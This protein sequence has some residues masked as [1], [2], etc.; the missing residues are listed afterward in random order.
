MSC[1]CDVGRAL[2]GGR[3][4]HG[5][6]VFMQARRLTFSCRILRDGRGDVWVINGVNP[7]QLIAS[8]PSASGPTLLS[9]CR[10]AVKW[11]QW[12]G[13]LDLPISVHP[14]WSFVPSWDAG[15]VKFERFDD[16][17]IEK[18]D[19]ILSNVRTEEKHLA[20]SGT[21]V[22][23]S[24]SFPVSAGVILWDLTEEKYTNTDY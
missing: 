22:N 10:S 23:L 5:E 12:E 6:L 14:R 20:I 7:L 18:R 4:M 13:M 8:F 9:L 16:D 15:R 1:K 17:E 2:A 11:H 3:D 24:S 19:E 21:R